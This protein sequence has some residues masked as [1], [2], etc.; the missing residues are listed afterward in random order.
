M[1]DPRF[2]LAQINVARMQAPLEDP[3]MEGFRSQLDA[4]NAIADAA[5]G[6]VW[7]LQ[8]EGGDATALRVFDDPLVLVNMSVWE[9][10][11]ALHGYVYQ[12][13]HVGPLRDRREWFLPY[14]GPMLALW[15]V[16]AGHTPTVAEGKAKLDDLRRLG[17]SPNAF[18]FRRPFPAPGSAPTPAPEFPSQGCPP[19]TTA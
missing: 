4:I 10:L 19:E 5:P 14:D 16:P 13:P 2:H 1:S 3:V 12:S 15:W 11:E 9:S 18:T 7:R 8:T 6:F 17:P